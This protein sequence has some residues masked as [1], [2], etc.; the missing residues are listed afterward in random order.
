MPIKLQGKFWRFLL[1]TSVCAQ[2]VSGFLFGTLDRHE[3]AGIKKVENQWSTT[4]V[5]N[6]R[7]VDQCI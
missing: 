1:S 7:Y 5:M 4:V 6:C 2:S 3:S